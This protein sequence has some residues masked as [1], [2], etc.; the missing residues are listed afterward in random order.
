MFQNE[1]PGFPDLAILMS[2]II[3][4]IMQH[5]MYSLFEDST[6]CTNC[7]HPMVFKKIFVGGFP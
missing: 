1:R 3:S 5:G 6:E 2:C 4:K 7:V